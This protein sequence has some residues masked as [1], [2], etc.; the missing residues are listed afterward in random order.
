MPQGLFRLLRFMRGIKR[1]KMQKNKEA[2]KRQKN[3]ECRFVK[4]IG[5]RTRM[6]KASQGASWESCWSGGYGQ[7]AAFQSLQRNKSGGKNRN[8]SGL[9]G[10]CAL[11][12]R[13][14]AAC[15]AG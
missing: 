12:C 8:V 14:A 7:R 2:K 15:K 6:E 11:L 3:G 5:Q 1:R 4:H 10:G 13:Y 9:P